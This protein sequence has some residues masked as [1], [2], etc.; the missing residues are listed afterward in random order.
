MDIGKRITVDPAVQHGK[1]V[2]QGTRVPVARLVAA[3]AGGMSVSEAAETYG[4]QA[5]DVSAALNYA[6]VLVDGESI[7][8]IP[9]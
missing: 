1:P 2:V 6:A 4:V 8:P 5:E 9:G 7:Y 3:V